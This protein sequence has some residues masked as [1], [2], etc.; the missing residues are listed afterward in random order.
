MKIAICFNGLIRTGIQCVPNIKKYIGD[1]MPNCDFFVHT[2][3]YETIKPFARTHWNGMP[4]PKPREPSILSQEKLHTFVSQYNVVSYVV[5]NYFEFTKENSL[6]P[7]LPH[8][9]HTTSRSLRL[10]RE[11][12]VSTNTKYD[13]VIKIR[14]DVIFPIG[15]T[16]R[17][18]LANIDLSKSV[19]YSNPHAEHRLD[20]VFWIMNNEVANKMINVTAHN[21]EHMDDINAIV[22]DFLKL[23]GI[24][25]QPMG[26]STLVCY[27]IYRYE[28]YMLDP[29][30]NFGECFL[31]DLLHYSNI[32][33]SK[34]ISNFLTIK[35]TR[36]FGR[37]YHV[38][39][40]RT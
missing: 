21:S 3:D 27:T 17:Q 4:L 16:L 28:S 36:G 39:G 7:K 22:L 8:V 5:D 6:N 19:V 37:F 30:L 35:S 23:N 12:E 24:E 31:N 15:K 10:K 13:V 14:P 33:D 9:W 32:P 34:I 1:L 18:D 29:I 26:S 2:W 40:L 38:F 11:H 25:H 20:D